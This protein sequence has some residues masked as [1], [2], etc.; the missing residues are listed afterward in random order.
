MPGMAGGIDRRVIAGAVAVPLVA[1][2]VVVAVAVGHGDGDAPEIPTTVATTTETIG[3]AAV[4][5]AWNAELGAA[6]DPLR[7]ALVE[8]AS[9]VAAHSTGELD[10]AG[11]AAVLDRLEPVLS[12]VRDAVHGLEPHRTDALAGPLVRT[13]AELYVLAIASHRASLAVD[14][15]A[16][17]QYDRLGRRLR[18]LG[19]RIFDRA[20]ERT[21]APV[22]PGPD[23]RLVRPAEVPDWERLELAAGPPLE[24]TD[25]NRPD[26][27]P[28]AREDRRATQPAAAWRARVDRL[29]VPGVAEVQRAAGDPA[30]LASLARQLVE[31]AEIL[32]DEPV[33][34]GDRGRA[35]RLALGWLVRADAARASQ[36][37]ALAPTPAGA[38]TRLAEQLLALSE[39][40]ALGAT[41]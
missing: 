9:S 39:E 22:D 40:P 14:G 30:A 38:P 33:P 37:A 3:P 23:V 36:L 34:D 15:D 5:E 1:L 21:S 17:V 31:A 13:T 25:R 29:D 27:E 28:L 2:A 20:R 10:R 19:D 6:L 12:S 11:L 24:P 7:E 4:D 8:L 16:A 26:D 35:D 32:R 18:I 41:R